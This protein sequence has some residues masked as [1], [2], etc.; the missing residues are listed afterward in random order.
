MASAQSLN[1]LIVWFKVLK[2]VLIWKR[3]I[4]LWLPWNVIVRLH[5]G[6]FQWWCDDFCLTYENPWAFKYDSQHLVGTG[7]LYLVINYTEIDTVSASVSSGKWN[8]FLTSSNVV[9]LKLVTLF[10]KYLLRFH[11]SS[12]KILYFSPSFNS[13]NYWEKSDKTI[14]NIS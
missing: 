5:F 4:S 9:W 14:L 13:I 8:C 12:F 1:C 3:G 10:L 11:P 7:L 6:R 2:Q